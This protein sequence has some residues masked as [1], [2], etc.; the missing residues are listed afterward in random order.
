MNRF[1]KYLNNKYIFLLFIFSLLF[2]PGISQ[3]S[4]IPLYEEIVMVQGMIADFTVA[5]ISN[6]LGF[7]YSFPTLTYQGIFSTSGWNGNLSGKWLGYDLTDD[8]VGTVDTSSSTT[9]HLTSKGHHWLLG[10]YTDSGTI[11]QEGDKATFNLNYTFSSGV[12]I[13]FKEET[14][15]TKKEELG[16]IYIQ[17]D[18]NLV[19]NVSGFVLPCK[20]SVQLDKGTKTFT[21]KY[22]EFGFGLESKGE[23]TDEINN[24]KVTATVTAVPV[25]STLLL[26]GSGLTGF[27]WIKRKKLLGVHK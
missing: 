27:A 2:M 5:A 1:R 13:T 7:D 17:G 10:D 3:G 15:L 16:K 22:S 20:I 11:H 19:D 6:A 18:V 23:F 8:Y 14:P 9:F 12:N 4:S 25:P 26:L 24:G 21:S